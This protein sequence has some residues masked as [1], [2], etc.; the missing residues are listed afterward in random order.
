[1]T[2]GIVTL[3]IGYMLGI[4]GLAMIV[5][6]LVDLAWGHP[7]WHSFALSALFT[8]FAAGTLVLASRGSSSSMSLRQG[9]ILT[10]V[11]WLTA[12]MFGALPFLFAE[13]RIGFAD[14][15][16]EAISG[17]TTTG[18]TVLS[19]LDT[20]PPGLLVW[21]SMLQWIGGV[22]IIVMGIVMLPFLRV[23]GMQLFRLESSDRSSEKVLPRPGQLAAW[24][25]GIYVV[26]TLACSL[27]YFVFGMSGFDAINHAMTTV[28]TGGYSTH[29][30]SLGYFGSPAIYWTATLFMLLGALPFG[31]YIVTARRDSLALL[32]DTQVQGFLGL[33]AAV[34]LAL[35]LWRIASGTEDWFSALTAVAV[36]TAS[37]IT[38]TG[39]ATEDYTLWGSA[40]V[41]SFFMLTFLGGCAGSTSGGFK[42]YRLQIAFAMLVQSLR[43]TLTPHGVFP[44]RYGGRKVESDVRESVAGFAMLYALTIAGL[45]L[46]LSFIG[47]DFDTAVS[48]ALT[49]VAN[50][51]PGIGSEIGPAGNF[52]DLPDAAKWALSLGMLL[53]RLEIV[54]VLVLLTPESWRR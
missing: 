4:L 11:S 15:F 14:S 26:L 27:L 42:T 41:G 8:L 5:P 2:F 25:G 40:A 29:D 6:A 7:D 50:V 51:G 45:A 12:S 49:A 1:M 24:I 3:A 22:G 16:F 37:V 43:S 53:G 47:L 17:L 19:G 30:A 48:G 32:R 46:V 34:W 33:I 52:A 38:T 13:L 39:F 54:T 18:S 9:F 10:V 20:L 36:N 28:S 31:I 23:G 35:T 21:R 44:A